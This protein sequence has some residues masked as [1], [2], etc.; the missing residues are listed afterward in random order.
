MARTYTKM[1]DKH[2]SAASASQVAEELAEQVATKW[3][4]QW[5]PY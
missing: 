3:S 4:S 2:A 5:R 1:E